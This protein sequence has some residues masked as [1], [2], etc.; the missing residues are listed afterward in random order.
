MYSSTHS[1]ASV[2]VGSEWS[3][4]RPGR[5]TLRERIPGIRWIG[6]RVGPRAVLDTV[7]KR[8]IPTSRRESNSDHPLVEPVVSRYTD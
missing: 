8:K 4:S 2:L 7:S 3:A 6:G 1:L 5:C